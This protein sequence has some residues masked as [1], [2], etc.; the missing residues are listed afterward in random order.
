[1]RGNP[2]PPW[3]QVPSKQYCE[4][5]F[6]RQLLFP[7]VKEIFHWTENGRSLGIIWEPLLPVASIS[8]SESDEMNEK[9]R[10]EALSIMREEI[11]FQFRRSM[12]QY[13]GSGGRRAKD[14]H[15]NSPK[16]ITFDDLFSKLKEFVDYLPDDYSSNLSKRDKIEKAGREEKQEFMLDVL[17]QSPP[18]HNLVRKLSK[19]FHNLSEDTYSNFR[20][21]LRKCSNRSAFEQQKQHQR[22]NTHHFRGGKKRKI[23]NGTDITTPKISFLDDIERGGDRQALVSFGGISLRI[24]EFHLN[25]MKVLF[26]R[27][28]RNEQSNNQFDDFFPCALFTTLLRYDALEGAGLQSAIPSSVF[29][30]LNKKYGCNWECFA[31]PFNCWLEKCS[32]EEV[33]NQE[34][35]R[36]G[37]FGCAFGDTDAWF[38]GSGN[39]YGTNFLQLAREGSGCFQANPP[40][41]S[42]FIASMCETIDQILT[43]SNK[44]DDEIPLMFIIF[45]PAWQE[46]SGWKMLMKSSFLSK[47]ILLSQKDD[48]HYYAEGTQHRRRTTKPIDPKTENANNMEKVLKGTSHR[49]ASFDTSVFFFQ[50]DSGKRK[51]LIT[52]DDEELLKSAFSMQQ[53]HESKFI[54]KKNPIMLL[55]RKEEE[56]QNGVQQRNIIIRKKNKR[57]KVREDNSSSVR[58][59]AKLVSGE[60]DE[61][62]ILASLNLL[63]DGRAKTIKNSDEKDHEGSCTKMKNRKKK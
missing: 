28:L 2:I 23:K 48:V 42:N 27:N 38:G 37:K 58:K 55:P 36:G 33:E 5:D 35:F 60:N 24:N 1:M 7:S 29:R 62:G 4:A 11:Q 63:R 56:T 49:I 20:S 14:A 8:D 41:A 57:E 13:L 50:N 6:V 44:G 18:F 61:L 51:W 21:E 30:L 54:D 16:A 31:S 19:K 39:F 3:C 43:E 22:Q 9:Y 32:T 53:I 34:T 59:K 15:G 25:K 45:V 46:S 52:G 12:K 47:H 26:D 17:F 40:F 10:K